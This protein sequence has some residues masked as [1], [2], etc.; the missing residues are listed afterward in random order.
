MVLSFD[1]DGKQLKFFFHAG[2]ALALLVLHFLQAGCTPPV[3][4]ALQRRFPSLV[5]SKDDII[6]H[7]E[8]RTVPACVRSLRSENT[9]SLGELLAKFFQ[10]YSSFDWGRTIS[11]RNGGTQSTPPGKKWRN[12]YIRIEDPNDLG[13]VTRSVFDQYQFTRIKNAFNAADAKLR[14]GLS[15]DSIF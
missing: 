5:P 7:L 1:K 4:P 3:V 14:R 11:V 6:A 15:L 9:Q 13:N 10:Y 12:P 2:F 8:E